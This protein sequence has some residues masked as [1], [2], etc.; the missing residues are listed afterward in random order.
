[1]SAKNLWNPPSYKVVIMRNS[2]RLSTFCLLTV[3]TVDLLMSLLWLRLG[4]QEGNPI[5][6]WFAAFGSIPFAVAKL[7][8]LAGPVALLEFARKSHPKSAEQGTWLAT[9]FYILF[10]AL[11][12]QAAFV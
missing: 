7:G 4:Y 9:G 11:H 1:M 6:A 2:V 3:G 10:L 5:F 8:F 12:V